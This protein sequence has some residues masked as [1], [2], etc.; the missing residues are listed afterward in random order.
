M[1]KLCGLGYKGNVS[2]SSSQ[3]QKPPALSQASSPDDH[4]E[5]REAIFFKVSLSI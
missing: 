4:L 5:S 2:S 1:K 3:G